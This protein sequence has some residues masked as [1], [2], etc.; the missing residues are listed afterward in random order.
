V[1]LLVLDVIDLQ[2]ARNKLGPSS[3]ETKTKSQSIKAKRARIREAL[4]ELA[5]WQVRIS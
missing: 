5:M 2:H 1:Q 4:G 3:K